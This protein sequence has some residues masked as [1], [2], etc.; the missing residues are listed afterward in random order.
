M[1]R[2]KN[3]P[4]TGLA[5]PTTWVIL[6]AQPAYQTSRSIAASTTFSAR[7]GGEPLGLPHRVDELRAPALHHLGDAVEDLARLY[8]VAP[9]QPPKALRAAR[10]ASRASLRE[11]RAAL[12]RNFPL[13]SLTT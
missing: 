8:A 5:P 1:E 10:T 7:A 3:G 9:D 12:A 11:A 4:A 2:L 13:L 6:S